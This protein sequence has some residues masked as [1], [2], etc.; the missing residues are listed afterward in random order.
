MPQGAHKD[1]TVIISLV[2][3][4]WDLLMEDFYIEVEGLQPKCSNWQERAKLF[5]L[6]VSKR[7]LPQEQSTLSVRNPVIRNPQGKGP[8]KSLKYF[9]S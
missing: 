7:I 5:N 2:D 3:L 6:V 1:F 4:E 8:I 9:K